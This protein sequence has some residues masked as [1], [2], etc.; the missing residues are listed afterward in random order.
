MTQKMKKQDQQILVNKLKELNDLGYTERQI[1]EML[2]KSRSTLGYYRCKYNIVSKNN[3]GAR[4][5]RL[6]LGNSY[7]N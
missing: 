6:P 4:R 3:P 7:Q 2:K 1:A 5:K